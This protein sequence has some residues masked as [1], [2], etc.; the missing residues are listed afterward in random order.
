M[1]GTVN[2]SL[3]K[4]LTPLSVSLS[5][6]NRTS[7]SIQSAV[8]SKS[9]LPASNR[10]CSGQICVKHFIVLE[11]KTCRLNLTV[12]WIWVSVCTVTSCTFCYV[13][14]IFGVIEECMIRG[15]FRLPI[16]PCSYLLWYSDDKS[17]LS[18]SSKTN[19]DNI[20][21]KCSNCS[22]K[23]NS[24]LLSLILQRKGDKRA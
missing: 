12:A 17:A 7:D 10:I 5:G 4:K 14:T 21:T 2:W 20:I 23:Y 16:Y 6:N 19:F 8:Y 22:S 18:G 3:N 24:I 11:K 9:D 15:I 13:T 1:K